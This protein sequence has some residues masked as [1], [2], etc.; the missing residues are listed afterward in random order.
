VHHLDLRCVLHHRKRS[1]AAFSNCR[2]GPRLRS[3]VGPNVMLVLLGR[4][5]SFDTRAPLVGLAG[6]YVLIFGAPVSM[7]SGPIAT[8]LFCP[9]DCATGMYG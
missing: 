5:S 8:F 1:F 6:L 2:R 4:S 7:F 9:L 3:H